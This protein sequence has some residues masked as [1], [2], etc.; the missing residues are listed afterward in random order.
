MRAKGLVHSCML[1]THAKNEPR[2][3]TLKPRA[4]H[5][6]R[7]AARERQTTADWQAQDA[8]RA[9]AVAYLRLAEEVR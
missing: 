6:A 8:V 5:A 1:C 4:D 7:L 9:G 3:L 2:A